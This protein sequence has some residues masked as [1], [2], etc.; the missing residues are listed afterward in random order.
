MNCLSKQAVLDN[1]KKVQNQI[2]EK[3]VSIGRSPEE[4]TLIAVTKGHPTEHLQPAFDAGSRHFGENRV[5]EFLEKKDAFPNELNW[6]LI[7]SLQTNKINKILGKVAL[8]HSVDSIALAQA[9]SKRSVSQGIQTSILLQVNSSGES[10]KHG[11]SPEGWKHEI[12]Q[13]LQLENLSVEGLMTMAPLTKDE[14]VIRKTFSTLRKFKEE[15]TPTL[16]L[17]HLS[18]GMSHDY[19]IAIEEGATLLR[20]GSAIFGTRK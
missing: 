20:V 13:L 8:I 14:N 18:M 6:H 5:Q 10:S 4:I 1:Y 16:P 2:I 12:D 19:L 17:K 3:A 15:L 9:I 7:G 11:L